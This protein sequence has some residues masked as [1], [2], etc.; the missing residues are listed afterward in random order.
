MDTKNLIIIRCL[1]KHGEVLTQVDKGTGK[2]DINIYTRV[3]QGNE[4]QAVSEQY[5]Q[6]VPIRYKSNQLREI[7]DN[8]KHQK[9]YKRLTHSTIIDV[10]RL[11]LNKRGS[12]G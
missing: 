12:R 7:A 11:Q 8:I 10:R 9:Q 3:K 6:R 5:S 4:Q 1:P 2:F